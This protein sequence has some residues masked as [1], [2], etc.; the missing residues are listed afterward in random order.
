VPYVRIEPW[1]AL[2]SYKPS[3]VRQM[4]RALFKP[5]VYV[6]SIVLYSNETCANQPRN[7]KRERERDCSV[8][9]T[10]L[11]LWYLIESERAS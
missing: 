3:P 6:P 9:T 10:Y 11:L 4:C 5:F 7:T 1:K 2:I 8:T